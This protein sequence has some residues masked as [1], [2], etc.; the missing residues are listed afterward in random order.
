[1]TT[2]NRCRN[3]SLTVSFFLILPQFFLPPPPPSPLCNVDLEG[4]ACQETVRD[5]ENN[6]E[7]GG[8]EGRGM[9]W[10]PCLLVNVLGRLMLLE[11]LSTSCSSVKKTRTARSY[12][13][14]TVRIWE[15][16]TLEC[17]LRFSVSQVL[18]CIFS[19]CALT[20]SRKLLFLAVG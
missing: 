2:E 3:H 4:H 12:C 14:V 6:I 9:W 7:L 10:F 8:G 13:K 11:M 16:E 15:V 18:W 20:K 1:M 17:K 19:L 5:P